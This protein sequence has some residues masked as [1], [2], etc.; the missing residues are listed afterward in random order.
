MGRTQD[1]VV[2]T[3]ANIGGGW[4]EKAVQAGPAPVLQSCKGHF[5]PPQPK[6]IQE[7]IDVL[8]D[9]FGDCVS[10]IPARGFEGLDGTYLRMVGYAKQIVFF[11]LN[12]APQKLV[13]PI[14]KEQVQLRP[15]ALFH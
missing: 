5:V 11:D 8:P 2:V 10:E 3:E 12:A 4:F 7:K 6:S 14:P 1:L 13:T 15:F 9:H